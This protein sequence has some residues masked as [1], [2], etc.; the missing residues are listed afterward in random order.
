MRTLWLFFL[1]MYILSIVPVAF[2]TLAAWG[3]RNVDLSGDAWGALI[4]LGIYL[5]G[6]PVLLLVTKPRHALKDAE[7]AE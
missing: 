3:E 7:A 2:M 4:T 1:G 6:A 5:I